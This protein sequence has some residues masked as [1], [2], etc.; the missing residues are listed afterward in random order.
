MC[1]VSGGKGVKRT[2]SPLSNILWDNA[3]YVLG[4]ND[5][6]GRCNALFIEKIKGIAARHTEDTSIQAVLKYY[7]KPEIDRDEKIIADPLYSKV[8]ESLSANFSFRYEA[9]DMLIA[10]KKYLYEHM[11]GETS[12]NSESGRCLV[13]G[14]K[15]PLVR[16][17]TPTPL[18]DNSPMAALVAFQ[19]NSGYDSYG[20]SQAYNSPISAVAEETFSAVLKRLLGK[21][22]RNKIRLC[23]RMLLFWGNGTQRICEE[24]ED[25]LM[26]ILDIPDKKDLNLDEKINKVSKLF[27]SIFSGEIK[28]TLNDR[29][30]I[31]GLAPNTG[32]IAVVLWMDSELKDFAGKILS[33]FEDMEIVDN[34]NPDKRRPYAGVFSMV[35]AVTQGVK[36]QTHCQI[37]WMRQS[38][39][40]F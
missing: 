17:T 9:D 26:S 31:L 7:T 28:T 1:I 29:F 14:V 12:D 36:S 35:S 16:T 19:V 27:K 10:E 18:P 5:K 20:K 8:E 34:R 39:Q 21:G 40:L 33:H 22:S 24:V 32:R 4:K 3:K 15:G 38:K 2:S 37:S 23:N 25:G 6:D 30:H 11:L 13:T